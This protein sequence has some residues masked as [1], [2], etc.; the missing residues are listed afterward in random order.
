MN[1]KDVLFSIFAASVTIGLIVFMSILGTI[2]VPIAVFAI[3]VLII[4]LYIQEDK[5]K[6]KRKK[7][8]W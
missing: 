3:L 7:S 6:K 1:K 8:K 5:K 2:L 4:Y